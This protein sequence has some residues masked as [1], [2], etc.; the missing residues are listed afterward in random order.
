MSA[1]FFDYVRGKTNEVPVGYDLRGFEAYR[2]LVRLGV[3][4]L[5]QAAFPGLREQLGE[6]AWQV[7]TEDFIRQSQWTSHFYGDLEHEFQTYLA[8]T[9]S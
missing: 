2:Y 9:L 7:L 5:L 6:S 1:A 3:A 4:Q 8:R